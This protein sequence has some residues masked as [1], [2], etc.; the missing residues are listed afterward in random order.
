[1]TLSARAQALIDR[2]G[3]LPHPEGG[4]YRELFRS[5]TQIRREDG[6]A[7]SALTT[8][9][10]LLP[11]GAV[12]RWHRVHAADEV[13]HHYEGDPLELRVLPA[14]ASQVQS[15]LLGPLDAG[16]PEV[17]PV[18]T[19]PADAWQAARCLGDYTLVGCT[20]GPGF[21]FADFVM[22]RDLPLVQRPAALDPEWL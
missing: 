17:L 13:W 14:Q 15:W 7:R 8:I 20:V 11:Q 19:V 18:H 10:F 4:Y 5:D 12:S 2:L 21:D 6:A 1:M 16:R 9:F 22:A 3:L